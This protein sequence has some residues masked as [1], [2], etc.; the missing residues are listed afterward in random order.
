MLPAFAACAYAQYGNY[1][2]PGYGRLGSPA[3]DN[4]YREGVQAGER[5]ARRNRPSGFEYDN[6]YRRADKGYNHRYGDREAYRYEF[7]RG[8]ERGYRDAYAANR[9]YGAYGD[10]GR[11]YPQQYPNGTYG[12]TYPRGGYSYRSPAAQYGFDEG[13]QKGREDARD[14]DPYDP[15]RQKWYREGDRHYNSRYGSRDQWK[16]DYRA[17]FKQGYDRGYREGRY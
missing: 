14:R 17:A 13:Y 4:G 8:Y 16:Y 6:D 12:G 15:V 9:G 3:Y 2:R 5:D 10:R 11:G 7:R 1:P